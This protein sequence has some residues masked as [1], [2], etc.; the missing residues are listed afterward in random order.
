MLITPSLSK[1][2]ILCKINDSASLLDKMEIY[3]PQAYLLTDKVLF[4]FVTIKKNETSSTCAEQF[5]A[6]CPAAQ[7]LTVDTVNF[8]IADFIG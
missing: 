3:L 4:F 6:G 1:N 2:T 7:R 5:S 8:A